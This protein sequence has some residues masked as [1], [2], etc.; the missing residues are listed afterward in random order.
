MST[1]LKQG[2][3]SKR[4]RFNTDWKRR[5]FVLTKSCLIYYSSDQCDD[6]H[7][8][9]EIPLP[10]GTKMLITAEADKRYASRIEIHSPS[11]TWL[12]AAPDEHQTR[13]WLS[14]LMQQQREQMNVP[15]V[16]SKLGET[17]SSRLIVVQV[18]IMG[19]PG[20][21][22][23]TQC[24]LLATSTGAQLVSVGEILRAHIK[25][26]SKLGLKA[27]DSVQASNVVP[28]ELM[29]QMLTQ[30]QQTNSDARASN[31]F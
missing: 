31:S 18:L 1:S 7:K 17:S 28:D 4:G 14:C 9:G 22:K 3:L 20:C 5:Y 11:R 6:A 8:K 26:G 21:G 30:V 23:T 15:T 25:L 24:R 29:V 12:L 13:L 27:R 19:P 2:F 10:S 16:A